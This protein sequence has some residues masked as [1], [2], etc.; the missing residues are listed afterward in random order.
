[1]TTNQ[2]NFWIT[3]GILLAVLTCLGIVF[4]VG[5]FGALVA[6]FGPDP[7]G[8]TVVVESPGSVAEGDEFQIIVRVGNTGA[9][10]I[11]ISEI[12][13]PRI[14]TAF[15]VASD[16]P[17]LGQTPMTDEIGYQFAIPL[18]P[19]ETQAVTFTLRAISAGEYGGALKTWVGTRSKHTDFSV[20]IEES[21][22]APVTARTPYESV[23]QIIA[24]V[25][26]GE[27]EVEGWTGSGSI[28]SPDGLIL[29]NAHVV[30]S[31]RYYD[32]KDLIVALTINPDQPPERRFYAEVMQ[33]DAALDIAVIRVTRDLAS[34]AL[35]HAALGLPAVK[36]GD[37]NAVQLG[38]PIV[39]LGYPG[40]GGD[41]IT[42]TSGEAA[43]FTAEEG[44]GN[45][46]FI[47]TSATIAGGNSGG[48]AANARGEL[49]GIP[50]QLGY[51]GDEEFVDCRPLADTNR[52]GVVDE[53][54]NC[55]PVGGF[56]NA[57]RPINLAMPFI[58]AARRGE[59]SIVQEHIEEST[60]TPSGTV[61]FE[62]DF[63]DLGSGWSDDVDADGSVGYESGEYVVRVD[64]ADLLIWG[65]PYLTF[66][67]VEITVETRVLES[68]GD[69]DYGMVC[70]YQDNQ[71][72]YFFFV[73]EDGFFTIGKIENDEFTPLYDWESSSILDSPDPLTIT[74]VC[75][76]DQLKL[77]VNDILLAEAADDA[78]V[79]GD[80]GLIAGTYDTPGLAVAFDNL[81]VR[82]P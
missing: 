3:C 64:T 10:P 37:S 42:L 9:Q 59:V 57:L 7:E 54:D 17:S 80:I 72:F 60:F 81:V 40:I 14:E 55:I 36:L 8:L 27:G 39:I 63:S 22:G 32:V 21:Q 23:V 4:I 33:A 52:D 19:G 61:I 28:I 77:A 67:D 24:I 73:S 49:I 43:G 41:T 58:E 1:M 38:D 53:E 65:R 31:D 56:I 71:N 20:V 66:E 76:G 47:K 51:G 30:L 34:N 68:V 45:R 2:R 50:T 11:T 18:A 44:V 78:F 25:D 62:D 5:G 15:V 13:L 46:A 75:Q 79:S 6:L 69:G 16:P 12:G 26:A 70:R 35:D 48:L 82:E 29:T 74:I